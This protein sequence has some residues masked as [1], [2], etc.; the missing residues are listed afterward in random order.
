MSHNTKP[1]GK[2]ITLAVLNKILSGQKSLNRES[3]HF[4]V[5]E[6]TAN[7]MY[8]LKTVIDLVQ[9]SPSS[10]APQPLDS[11]VDE[12]YDVYC[13]SK[14]IT[15]IYTD[16]FVAFL[17]EGFTIQKKQPLTKLSEGSE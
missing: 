10:T 5:K 17:S 2:E 7:K 9:L 4:S 1:E 11:I 12:Y 14:G 3:E 16:D 6:S 8:C 13:P 15:G